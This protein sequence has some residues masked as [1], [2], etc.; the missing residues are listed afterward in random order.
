ML[1]QTDADG[2]AEFEVPTVVQAVTMRRKAEPWSFAGPP[3]GKLIAL[4]VRR[5]EAGDDAEMMQVTMAFESRGGIIVYRNGSRFLDRKDVS[6]DAES[7]KAAFW[8]VGGELWLA[9]ADTGGL[10]FVSMDR[11]PRTNELLF[12]VPPMTFCGNKLVCCC[13]PAAK[14]KVQRD[15]VWVW[16]NISD[17]VEVPLEGRVEALCGA[18]TFFVVR[19]SKGRLFKC[20]S[21]GGPPQKLSSGVYYDDMVVVA[22]KDKTVIASV[23]DLSEKSP[24]S[25]IDVDT[26]DERG[27]LSKLAR[28]E[29]ELARVDGH[30]QQFATRTHW[31]VT[32]RTDKD[33]PEKVDVAVVSLEDGDVLLVKDFPDGVCFAAGGEPWFGV[34]GDGDS[35]E[36]QST[37]TILF[38]QKIRSVLESVHRGMTIGAPAVRTLNKMLEDLQ[39]RLL[40]RDDRIEHA[41]RGELAGEIADR[42]LEKVNEALE[43]L[44]KTV[45]ITAGSSSTWW[46]VNEAECHDGEL[47]GKAGLFFDVH[48][49]GGVSWTGRVAITACLE[50]V[51]AQILDQAGDSCVYS[52]VK[53]IACKHLDLLIDKDLK[54]SVRFEDAMRAFDGAAPVDGELTSLQGRDALPRAGH[55]RSRREPDV[56]ERYQDRFH[57]PRRHQGVRI[58]VGSEVLQIGGDSLD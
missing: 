50:Y 13:K 54:A 38:C 52:G 29:F 14:S 34:R 48:R 24:S 16:S 51:C 35:W 55:V 46:G 9:L 22:G 56:L 30:T 11:L 2:V 53:Q 45:G 40:L 37:D 44:G 21:D 28:Y 12:L 1:L 17:S 4:D 25:S 31:Y 58:Q 10:N 42:A 7:L 19:D 5:A 39:R 18:D 49:I 27:A 57:G 20:S 47:K 3:G 33:E 36:V 43:N 32:V 6:I 15:K 41:I 8:Y 26:L 23:T